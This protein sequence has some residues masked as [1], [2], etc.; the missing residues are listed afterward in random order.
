MKLS[1][2]IWLHVNNIKKHNLTVTAY[3][4]SKYPSFHFEYYVEKCVCRL[5]C[6]TLKLASKI[7]HD[8]KQNSNYILENAAPDEVM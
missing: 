6:K 7:I 4:Q 2:F 3:I 5:P 1:C 8:D